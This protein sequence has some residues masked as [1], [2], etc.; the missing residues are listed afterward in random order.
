MKRL[1][2]NLTPTVSNLIRDQTLHI[3]ADSI[4]NALAWEDRL[5][6]A[7]RSLGMFHGHAVDEDAT[8]RLGT[9]IQ[10]YVFEK[11]YLVHYHVNTVAGTVEIIGFR[12]GAIRQRQDEP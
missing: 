10:K 2:V 11:T 7:I 9:K 3:A 1:R 12:H 6:T 5:L 4:D 8:D